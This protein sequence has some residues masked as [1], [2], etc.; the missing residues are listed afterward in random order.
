MP[1]SSANR[2]VA[3]LPSLAWRDRER[4]QRNFGLILSRVP[5]PVAEAIPPLLADNPDPDA[6]LNF[7]ERLT[8][9]AETPL[10]KLLA[11]TPRLIHYALLIFGY[12]EYLGET[13]LRNPDLLFGFQRETELARS[14][15]REE[16]RDA[17]ELLRAQIAGADVSEL[18]CRFKRR[19]YVRIM[20][21]DVLGIAALSET[22]SEISSLS[23]VLIEEALA[24]CE[25][26]MQQRFDTPMYK[27]REGELRPAPFSVLALGKL[28][29]NELNYS[30]D[31]DLMFLYGDE[32]TESDFSAANREYFL[33]LGQRVTETLTR[34]TKEG[35]VFRIDLRLRPQGKEGESAIS[36][37]QAL[38]Y[39]RENAHDWERQAMIKLRRCAGDVAL[40]SRFVR[41]LQDAIYTHNVNFAAIE[42]AL[43]TRYKMRRRRRPASLEEIDVKLD[44]G[45]IR[46]IEFLAQCLQ[47]VHGGKEWWLR[48][49][50]TLFSLQKLH[51]KQHLTGS[52]FQQLTAAYMF[53]R[54]LEHR[55]QLKHGQQTHRL[56]SN[57]EQLRILA[58][59]LSEERM[60]GADL[61]ATVRTPMTE[62]SAIYERIIHH[63]QQQ[64]AAQVQ[65]DFELRTLDLSFGRVQSDRQVLQRLAFDGQ[66]LYAIASRSDLDQS[67]RRNLFRFLSSTLTSGEL[68]DVVKSLPLLVEKSLDLFRDSEFLTDILVRH[69]EDI[70]HVASLRRSAEPSPSDGTL[71]ELPKVSEDGRAFR[72]YLLSNALSKEEKLKLLRRRFRYRM[73]LAGARDIL[74]A[75]PVFASLADTTAAAEEA[76]TTAFG[77]TGAEGM[78]VL[79]LGRLG[80]REFDVLSDADLLFIRH[81][82]VHPERASHVA[83][84]FMHTLSAYTKE[85]TVLAA[86]VR[87]RPHGTDGE[88]VITPRQLRAYFA[89]EAQAWEAL[90]YTKLRF[91]AGDA[92]LASDATAVIVDIFDRFASEESL[93]QDLIAMRVRL[94][95]SDTSS[96]LKTGLG[97]LY[98]ID[99]IV[100][101]LTIRNRVRAATG[102]LRHRLQKL[103][104]TGLIGHDDLQ[105]LLDALDLWRS[106]EH[107]TRL[108]TGRQQREMP[109]AASTRRSVEELVS[110]VHASEIAGD[111]STHCDQTREV[112]RRIFGQIV[113][114]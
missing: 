58:R 22:T 98:D 37:G 53:L 19:E 62:V 106:L 104:Q 6:A 25:L 35:M 110:R 9:R 114:M 72:E 17:I 69:P 29:G 16:Y 56:P 24:A 109:V 105:Q 81:E 21:R 102:N 63:Q 38:R 26:A 93:A 13:L 59:S 82:S 45:G 95:Q 43:Q 51:D 94:E 23:D 66:G 42:T 46:D 73:F 33:K 50:G 18:L 39:Y 20:L 89:G 68:Y 41:K 99:F 79:A 76:I 15:T 1:S 5:G 85:G 107:A 10:L 74:E 44:P 80:T 47:R 67:T 112:V 3:S 57:E 103:G 78:A 71:L 88:L 75:R 2:P 32:E 60:I 54:K 113:R 12:S 61:V 11:D 49:G 108:V 87:L 40:A 28:G 14:R 100:G 7:F 70:L 90:T 36:I 30:S 97:G 111:I 96:S 48:S 83:E 34:V 4:A 8:E 65:D 31:V 91:V 64:T 86:D 92:E 27:T 55:L 52:D 84:E 77:M 101:Y